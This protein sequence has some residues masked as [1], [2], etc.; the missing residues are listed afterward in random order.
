MTA[1]NWTI[2]LGF[3]GTLL[4]WVVIAARRT[5]AASRED[6]FFKGRD[7]AGREIGFVTLTATLLI[8]WIFA[9]S[10]QNAADLGMRFG[11]PGGVAYATYWLSFLV[12]GV[13]IYRLRQAGF[14]SIHEFLGSRF[15]AVAVWVFSLILLFRL[16]NEIWSNTM[17][18]AQFFGEMGSGAFLFAAWVTT[19]LVLGYSL[20][21]GFRGSIVTDVLQMGLAVAVLAVIL[22]FVFPGGSPEAMVRSGSWT[23]A[24]GVDLILVALIQCFSYPFH[25]PVMTDRGFLTR[26]RTML[27]GFFVAGGLGVV[28]ILLFSFVGIFNHVEGVGG[29]STIDTA[30]VLGLPALLMVNVM[31]LTSASSTLDSAF[32]STGKLVALDL[33]PGTRGDRFG[34]IRLGGERLE[35]SRKSAPRAATN[36]IRVARLTMVILALLGGAMVHMSPAILSATTVSGTMVIGLTPVFVLWR[37]KRPG[38]ASYLSSVLLGL[39]LGIGLALGW[40][41]GAIGEGAYGNLLFVNAVGVAA[42][43]FV[44]VGIAYLRPR[45]VRK[46]AP[47]AS[48]GGEGGGRGGPLQTSATSRR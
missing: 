19:L 18:V 26:P 32:S 33:L 24:G 21:S 9:K 2:L 44:F 37:W 7:A 4:L 30:R 1:V 23:L 27:R 47:K 5:G 11:L 36:P 28:F 3:L 45:R 14:R 41:P 8:S 46:Q 42:C 13:V 31:M 35:G 34:V 22:G 12:A 38:A 48:A 15:G 29:N 20:V 43:F 39:V 16:W 17:V 6:V 25:D 10:V 40:V